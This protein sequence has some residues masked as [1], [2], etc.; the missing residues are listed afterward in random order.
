[1]SANATK[2]GPER[3]LLP[4]RSERTTPAEHLRVLDRRVE[5]L[6]QRSREHRRGE[7]YDREERAALEWALGVVRERRAKAGNGD[8]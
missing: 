8:R 6:R 3:V 1:M 4:R 5:F 2:A 7:G